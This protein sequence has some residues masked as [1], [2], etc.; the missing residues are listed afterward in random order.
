MISLSD[1]RGSLVD[2]SMMLGMY[3]P[4]DIVLPLWIW[5]DL[6]ALQHELLRFRVSRWNEFVVRRGRTKTT[7]FG[8]IRSVRVSPMFEVEFDPLKALFGDKVSF[9]RAKIPTVYDGIDQLVWIRLQV[10]TALDTSYS[11]E[12]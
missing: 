1:R 12:A 3:T 9:V 8:T 6:L 11:F 5:H 10:T 7:L 4:R 2:A